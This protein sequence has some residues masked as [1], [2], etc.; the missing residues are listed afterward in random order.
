MNQL[1]QQYLIQVANEIRNNFFGVGDNLSKKKIRV[2]KKTVQLW[3]VQNLQNH[4]E[5]STRIT[6][7]MSST[8]MVT[9]TNP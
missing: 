4:V 1:H 5:V 8:I 9:V 6:D 2:Q 7:F 3:L